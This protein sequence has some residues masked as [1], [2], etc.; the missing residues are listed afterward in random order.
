MQ[1]RSGSDGKAAAGGGHLFNQ[2]FVVVLIGTVLSAAAINAGRLSTSLVMVEA[3]FSAGQISSATAISGLVAIPAMLLF[4]LL[5]D[6]LGRTHSLAL[7]YLFCASGAVMLFLAAALWQFWVAASLIMIAFCA[8]VSMSSAL[9]TD[10]LTPQ[11]LSRGLSIL[12]TSNSAGGILSFVSVGVIIDRL[13]PS[14]MAI[15]IAILPFIATTLLEAKQ[16]PE[17]IRAA[18]NRMINVRTPQ[19]VPCLADPSQAAEPC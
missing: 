2:G 17:L 5:S 13:G 8:N 1:K 11:T 7:A 3:N 18:A 15:A 16:K 12:S 19:P 10:Q 4:G 6:R 14:G 9:V